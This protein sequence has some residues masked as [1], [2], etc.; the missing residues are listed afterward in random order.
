MPN[1]AIQK[2]A[3]ATAEKAQPIFDEI[4][5]HFNQIRQR[6][7]ELFET[8]GRQLGHELDDWLKAE[9]EILGGW[10]AAELK[11]KDGKYELEVTLPGFDPKEVNVTATP[12]ELIV[13][14]ETRHEKKT[15]EEKVLWTEFGP[16]KVYRR[17]ELPEAIDVEQTKATLDNGLL[18]VVASKAPAAQRKHIEIAA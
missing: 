17:F 2:I 10:S 18:R 1:V 3:D 8:R 16:N 15:T 6:A 11:E 7:L 12:R 5:K 9:R 14:A 4:R 13:Q